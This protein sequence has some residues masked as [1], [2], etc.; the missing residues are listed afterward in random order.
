[1]IRRKI[2]TFERITEHF[3]LLT[4]GTVQEALKSGNDALLVG[5]VSSANTGPG[6]VRSRFCH[7]IF[8][9]P[10]RLVCYHTIY[11]WTPVTA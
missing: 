10:D 9:G 5:P 3:M 11:R 4:N 7:V 1:M 8:C 2:E 6:P